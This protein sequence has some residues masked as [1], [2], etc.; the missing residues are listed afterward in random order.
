MADIID[1]VGRFR[2]MPPLRDLADPWLCAIAALP[3]QAGLAT[4]VRAAIEA[5]ATDTFVDV[6]IATWCESAREDVEANRNLH[7]E[8]AT[9]FG[10]LR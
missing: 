8:L 2:Q 7:L 3:L 9:R 6:Y 5:G 4:R 1:A 10:A